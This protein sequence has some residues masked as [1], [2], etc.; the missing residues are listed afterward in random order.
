MNWKCLFFLGMFWAQGAVFAQSNAADTS[1]VKFEIKTSDGNI[2]R[3][4]VTKETPSTLTILREDGMEIEIPKYVIVYKKESNKKTNN[5]P[6]RASEHASRY[7]YS[8]SAFPIN[9]GEGYINLMYFSVVQAQYGLTDNFSI[10]ITSTP[11]LMPTLVNVKYSAKLDEK[12]HVSVGGQIGKL[13]FA[14]EETLGIGFANVTYGNKQE[15]FT[16]NAGY[17][18]YTGLDEQLPIFSA[19]YAKEMSSKVAFI[20]EFWALFPKTE[21][22]IYAGGP[23][24]RIRVGK[25]LFFDVGVLGLSFTSSGQYYNADLGTYEFQ[26]RRETY[27]PLPFLGLNWGL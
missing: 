9:K 7:L 24:M 15:N 6:D 13:W 3:G 19:C 10:G 23:A 26:R 11:I 21:G 17:G 12:L 14:E 27:T 1:K 25:N 4:T 5:V 18:F 16:F 20:T 2:H 8:P 22:A